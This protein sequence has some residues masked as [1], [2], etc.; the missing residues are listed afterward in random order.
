VISVVIPVKDG[1]LDLVRCLEAIARQDL[2]E[3]VE[4]VVV[5]SGSTDGS[6]QRARIAGARVHA[7]TPAE[8]SH[9][10][11]RNRGAELARGDVLVFTSQDAYAADDTWLARLVAP[12]R[13]DPSVA[14]VYGRQLPHENAIPS[15]RYFLDFLYGPEPRIQR[16][17]EARALSFE[18]TLYSNVNA[19]VRRSVWE[20]FRFADDLIMSED[21]EWS[22][23]VLLAGLSIAYEPRAAVRHSHAYSVTAAFRRFFDSGA[24]ASRSYVSEE[25]GSRVALRRAGARYAVGEVSWLW[26]TGQ[27]RWLPFAAV[28]ES[29]KFAGLQLGLRH[30]RLPTSLKRRLSGLPAYWAKASTADAEGEPEELHV[31]L[32]YDHLFPQTVGGAERWM[33]DLAL[34]LASTG[35]DVT[36]LTMRH[37]DNCEPPPLGAVRVV[38][39]TDAGLVYRSDRRT[40]LPPLRFGLGVARHLWR[41]GSEY[42]VVHVASFPYFPLLAAGALRPRRGYR[43]VVNWLEVWTRE[44]WWR[45]SGILIGTTGWLVQKACVL[46]PH[47]AYCLSDLHARR[48]VEAGYSGTPTILPGLY[49]GPVEPTPANLVHPELV[50]YAG[51]HVQ[52]KRVDALVRAFAIARERN[53][54]LRLELYGDGPESGRIDALVRQLGLASSVRLLGRRPEAEVEGAIARSACLATAS[55]REGYGLVVVEAAAHGT[56]SVVVAGPENAAT[57]LVRD[58]VNGA[59]SPDP[60]PASL[61]KAIERVV[62]SGAALRESTARWFAD[63]AP[64]LRIDRSLELI[65]EEYGR[66]GASHGWK[67]NDDEVVA[68]EDGPRP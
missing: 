43:L 16:L 10:G 34:H 68:P 44:Y 53:P 56:P 51:R 48:L 36:Y 26:R 32:V 50:V 45:Y 7:I 40:L 8:F 46:M 55:E 41:H 52:E 1:G 24:S 47:S 20:R 2:D 30:E 33:R 37:W 18:A 21:Q 15:E 38:G 35:Y 39:V 14:G 19:A 12:L 59:V 13:E 64:S 61:A 67:R 11:A 57:E 23:R 27:R 5:D 6:A 66:A 63:H 65:V 9:G 28:Y 25:R 17:D 22:R 54:D 4:V 62:E 49:A 31:C 60:S 58:G 3:E 29:A 42:D